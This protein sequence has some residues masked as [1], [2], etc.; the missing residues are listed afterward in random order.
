M[1][2]LRCAATRTRAPPVV[3]RRLTCTW[4]VSSPLTL[5]GHSLETLT[6]LTDG[7]YTSPMRRAMEA[8]LPEEDAPNST[9]A[10]SVAGRSAA[11][12]D[13]FTQ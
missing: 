2:V 13:F 3:A 11:D 5:S 4:P 1:T 10:A 6:A 12:G 8:T 7:R 9:L